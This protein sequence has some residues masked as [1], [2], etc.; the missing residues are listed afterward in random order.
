VDEWETLIPGLRP[1]GCPTVPPT[2]QLQSSSLPEKPGRDR[3]ILLA[4]DISH[5]AIQFTDIG[6]RVCVYDVAV[7][8]CQTL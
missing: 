1:S 5:N 7:N 3:Q 2:T 8:I 4:H 6:L